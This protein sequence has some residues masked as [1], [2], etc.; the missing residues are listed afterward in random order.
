[1]R[2]SIGAFLNNIRNIT[3]IPST[4]RAKRII[5]ALK[6]KNNFMVLNNMFV[7][8]LNKDDKMSTSNKL[9]ES[10]IKEINILKNEFIDTVKKTSGK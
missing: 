6:V 3:L 4:H 8:H 2:D 7:E 1:M 10:Y 5:M 9:I